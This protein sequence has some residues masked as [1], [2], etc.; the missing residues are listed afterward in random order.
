[1]VDLDNF[2]TLILLRRDEFKDSY[3]L[4]RVLSWKFGIITVSE[5]TEKLEKANLI[6]SSVEKGISKYEITAIGLK[7]IETN[8]NEGRSLLVQKYKTEQAFLESL[9]V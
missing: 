1:M 4:T 5:L 3:S 8:F 6:T 9:L 2:V 7:Y